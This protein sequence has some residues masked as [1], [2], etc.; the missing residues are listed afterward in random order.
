PAALHRYAPQ[1]PGPGTGKPGNKPPPAPRPQAMLDA[2]GEPRDRLNEMKERDDDLERK[3]VDRRIALRR[4]RRIGRG[5]S[6]LNEADD[7]SGSERDER[8]AQ[9]RPN[10]SENGE[11]GE[12]EQE[13]V[14]LRYQRQRREAAGIRLV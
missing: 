9:R 1:Q 6:R 8:P 3:T 11:H 2:A 5:A 4:E 13:K 10:N 14:P 12:R 7:Q